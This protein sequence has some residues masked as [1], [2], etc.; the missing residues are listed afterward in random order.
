MFGDQA[1]IGV[2]LIGAPRDDRAR[3]TPGRYA[4]EVLV[5]ITGMWG[6]VRET[7][8]VGLIVAGVLRKLGEERGESMLKMAV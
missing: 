4:R 6:E 7:S 8:V 5:W 2:V 3:V 1:G